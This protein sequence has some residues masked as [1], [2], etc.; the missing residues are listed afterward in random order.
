MQKSPFKLN[1]V[2]IVLG[3]TNW[4]FK[5]HPPINRNGITTLFSFNAVK[6]NIKV[7]TTM[8]VGTGRLR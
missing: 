1:D 2:Y 3:K 6:G 7:L 8:K 5:E 4:S